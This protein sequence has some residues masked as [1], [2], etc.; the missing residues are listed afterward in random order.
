MA[1]FSQNRWILTGALLAVLLLS[2]GEIGCS[3]C[4][5]EGCKTH[6]D[7]PAGRIC[8]NGRCEEVIDTG[9]PE[10]TDSCSE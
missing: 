7:C 9:E 6:S 1:T 4:K 8:V 2:F 3:G 10:E 5:D